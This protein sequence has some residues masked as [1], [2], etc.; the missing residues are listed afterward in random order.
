M[1]HKSTHSTQLADLLA[2]RDAVMAQ[3]AKP[4]KLPNLGPVPLPVSSHDLEIDYYSFVRL[5]SLQDSSFNGKH[6]ILVPWGHDRNFPEVPQH[7]H[8][9]LDSGQDIAVKMS[10]LSPAGRSTTI[11]SEFVVPMVPLRDCQPGPIVSSSPWPSTAGVAEVPGNIA[12]TKASTTLAQHAQP[13]EVI[14]VDSPEDD[15]IEPTSV[16]NLAEIPTRS[17]VVMEGS[18]YSRVEAEAVELEDEGS[19]EPVKDVRTLY[20]A[21]PAV[22]EHTEESNCH[23]IAAIVAQLRSRK[24]CLSSTAVGGRGQTVLPDEV[25]T[26]PVK[27][28]ERCAAW[29]DEAVPAVPVIEALVQGEISLSGVGGD[30]LH[31]AIHSGEVAVTQQDA[32]TAVCGVD[33]QVPV[34]HVQELLDMVADRSIVLGDVL[35]EAQLESW[36]LQFLDVVGVRHPLWARLWQALRL[37]VEMQPMALSVLWDLGA[38]GDERRMLLI[39]GVVTDL[40]KALRV[41]LGSVE[42]LFHSRL[43]IAEAVGG[44]GELSTAQSGTHPAHALLAMVL[45][46]LFPRSAQV[47][48]GWSR[49]GWSW[50]AWWA[51]VGRC[52]EC[53]PPWVAF[54]VL[55]LALVLMQERIGLPLFRQ[56]AWSD[57]G[58]VVKLRER[59]LAYASDSEGAVAIDALIRVM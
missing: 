2:R 3:E 31:G 50:A 33:T 23:T 42:A 48:W 17:A 58:R 7:V 47:G 18:A 25:S 14:D 37:P 41:K 35:D 57:V 45:V 8:V 34:E 5:H 56:D 12:V 49:T 20:L 43:G 9:C 19:A 55:A 46:E 59:L 51:F 11:T 1:R 40:L 27:D 16:D 38:S 30:I 39:P 4:P 15:V 32:G 10:K 6:G 21:H 28:V 13:L 36:F 53:A 29:Q 44:A 24:L 22:D 52:L 54:Q 26:G